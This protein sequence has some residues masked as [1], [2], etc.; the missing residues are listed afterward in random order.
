MT[1]PQ[2]PTARMGLGAVLRAM[3]AVAA[4]ILMFA[5]FLP[6][7]HSNPGSLVDDS[8]KWAVNIAAARHMVF[9]GDIM[10][11]YG[12]YAAVVKTSF[13]SEEKK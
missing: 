3:P 2:L 1:S 13:F 9:G 7:I 10:F 8:W 11:T 4:A 12:P 5:R 6:G